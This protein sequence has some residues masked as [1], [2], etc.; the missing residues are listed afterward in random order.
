MTGDRT[1]RIVMA[2]GMLAFGWIQARLVVAE[3]CIRHRQPT[4]DAC[5]S[6]AVNA[7][8]QPGIDA[9][10]V[11]IVDAHNHCFPDNPFS[12]QAWHWTYGEKP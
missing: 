10:Y 12:P 1:F 6:K 4:A 5:Y 8:D 9:C 3:H 11:S 7:L 2:C